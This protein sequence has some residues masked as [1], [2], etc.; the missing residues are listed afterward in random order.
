L[1]EE[2]LC[3]SALFDGSRESLERIREISRAMPLELR[4]PS[5]RLVEMSLT[6]VV[7]PLLEEGLSALAV[8]PVGDVRELL[9]EEFERLLIMA[10][11]LHAQYVVLPVRSEWIDRVIEVMSDFFRLGATYSKYIALEPS[12]EALAKAVAAMREYLGGVFKLSIA[13]SPASTTEELVALTLAHLGQVVAVKLANFTPEGGAVRL[14][15]SE[16]VINPFRV[17]KELLEHGYDSYFV[18]DYESFGLEL[19]PRLV[20]RDYVL[21]SQYLYSLVEK[22]R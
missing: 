5:E 7:D 21:L 3:Y 4:V 11:E 1:R 18:I 9:N 13:P 2:M 16:G 22:L 6:E 14:L 12:R 20:K 19:P 10:D 15:S 17:V 8:K